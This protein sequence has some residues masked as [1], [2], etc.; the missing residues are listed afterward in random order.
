M[1]ISKN[2]LL[3]LVT[4]SLFIACSPTPQNNRFKTTNRNDEITITDTK[5]KLEWVNGSEFKEFDGCKGFPRK[6]KNTE[7]F[8]RKAVL[9]HCASLT[10]AGHSDWRV[11]TASENQRF[12]IAT[13]SANIT[14][15]YTIKACPRV[16]GTRGD[17]IVSINTHNT[18]PMGEINAWVDGTNGGVRCVRKVR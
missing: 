12:V 16:I 11:P 4:L 2:Y 18:K 13:K 1:S 14:P 15:Y 5:T 9:E 3:P 8:I 17:N 6:P 7:A 10:F